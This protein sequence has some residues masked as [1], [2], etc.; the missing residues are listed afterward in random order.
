MRQQELPETGHVD[1][2]L[3]HD[4]I[5]GPKGQPCVSCTKYLFV[6]IFLFCQ[7]EYGHE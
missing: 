2:S 5:A 3:R 7:S 1:T 4:T 6:F